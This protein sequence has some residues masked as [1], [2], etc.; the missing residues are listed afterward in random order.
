MLQIV[1]RIGGDTNRGDSEP[2]LVGERYDELLLDDV[3]ANLKGQQWIGHY[4]VVEKLVHDWMVQ[5]WKDQAYC[6]I[7]ISTFR[8]D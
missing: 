6:V 5:G 3:V 4:E 1:V 2:V 8:C 7:P